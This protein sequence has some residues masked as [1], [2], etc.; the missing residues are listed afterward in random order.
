MQSIKLNKKKYSEK[1]HTHSD[2]RKILLIFFPIF[3]FIQ[4]NSGHINHNQIIRTEIV[5]VYL[6][7]KRPAN[8]EKKGIVARVMINK[9]GNKKFACETTI[10]QNKLFLRIII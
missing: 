8:F 10:T 4:F 5:M 7:L 9:T 1:L 3:Q 2:K 6:P